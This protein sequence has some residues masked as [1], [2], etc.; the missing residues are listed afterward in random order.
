MA[1][2]FVHS[3]ISSSVPII[4][5]ALGGIFTNLVGKLNVALEGMILTG[6]FVAL[7]VAEKTSSLFMALLASILVCSIYAMLMVLAAKLKANIFLAGI[8]MNL[9]ASGLTSL[10]MVFLLDSKGTFLSQSSPVLGKIELP[11]IDKIPFLG[12]VL[13]GYNILEYLTFLLALLCYILIS[14][15]TWGYKM[16]AVGKNPTVAKDLGIAVD[17]MIAMSFL[18]SALF[19]GLAGA[20]LSLPMRSFV[21][22]MSNNRG[23]LALVAV[24]LGGEKVFTVVLTCLIFGSFTFL[25][26][27]LQVLSK[28]PAELLMSLPYLLTVLVILFYGYLRKGVRV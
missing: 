1:A 11:F 16:R 6:A 5:A 2:D 23:W 13:S 19:T 3:V 26:N 22:G 20:A 8:A 10:L 9:F 17:E 15:S 4:L 27:F 25:S 14:K 7:Y 18:L 12:K 28:V 24:I 21:T